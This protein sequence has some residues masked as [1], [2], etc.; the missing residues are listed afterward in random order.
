[1]ARQL[2]DHVHRP[3]LPEAASRT[4]RSAGLTR[5]LLLLLLH[6][7]HSRNRSTAT[8]DKTRTVFSVLIAISPVG[9]ISAESLKLLPP[10][11]IF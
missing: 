7:A 9:T 11:V 3:A 10:N 8:D 2:G 4:P 5:V 6:C 1:V